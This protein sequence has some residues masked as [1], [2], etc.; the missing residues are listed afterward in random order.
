MMN[1]FRRVERS[2]HLDIT[3]EDGRDGVTYNSRRAPDDTNHATRIEGVEA[4]KLIKQ[5]RDYEVLAF[6]VESNNQECS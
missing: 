3:D 2:V 6:R 5:Q 1:L 4:E